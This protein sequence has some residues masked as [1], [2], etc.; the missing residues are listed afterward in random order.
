MWVTTN[1]DGDFLISSAHQSFSII[2]TA[3]IEGIIS[4]FDEEFNLLQTITVK[5]D[6]LISYLKWH[7]TRKFLAMG[8]ANGFY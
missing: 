3:N 5:K 6:S 7:P 8:F 4:T 2:A 1:F